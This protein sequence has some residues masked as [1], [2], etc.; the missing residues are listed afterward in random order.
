MLR[1]RYRDTLAAPFCLL[2][3]FSHLQMIYEVAHQLESSF[4]T[5]VLIELDPYLFKIY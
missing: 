2:W 3:S 4:E 5:G 1:A